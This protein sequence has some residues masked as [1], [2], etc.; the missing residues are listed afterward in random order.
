VLLHTLDDADDLAAVA[1]LIDNVVDS[2]IT[3]DDNQGTEGLVG[4]SVFLFYRLERKVGLGWAGERE[5]K[6]YPL[7]R[8]RK[9]SR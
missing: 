6:T 7:G 3:V 8:F 4:Q 2:H 5:A 1:G 9:K